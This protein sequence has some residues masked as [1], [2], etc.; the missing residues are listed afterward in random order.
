MGHKIPAVFRGRNCGCSQI[1]TNS[2]G[3]VDTGPI[4]EL[5]SCIFI[6]FFLIYGLVWVVENSGGEQI[7]TLNLGGQLVSSRDR[8]P[9]PVA[10]LM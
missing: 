10:M 4:A 1:G 6:V 8:K 2:K 9:P 7:D 5:L 3:Q